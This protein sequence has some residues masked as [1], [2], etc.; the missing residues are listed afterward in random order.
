MSWQHFRKTW[1]IK[2]W[3]PAPAVIAAGILS[4][5]YFG[6]TGTFW[7]VTGEFT[8]WGGQICSFLAFMPNSGATTS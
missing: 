1:L 6:I 8:R 5:Y 7:A 2:F 4:T 3:A